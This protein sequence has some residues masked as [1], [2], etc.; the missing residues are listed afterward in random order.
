[1]MVSV[2]GS[3]SADLRGPPCGGPVVLGRA[4]I[5]TAGRAESAAEPAS[6][7]SETRVL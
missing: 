1:M 6:T 4:A 5:G 2:L 7:G 3:E